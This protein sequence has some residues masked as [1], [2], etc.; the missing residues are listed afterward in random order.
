MVLLPATSCR[1]RAGILTY[2]FRG[3]FVWKAGKTGRH[4]GWHHARIFSNRC[5][6]MKSLRER[7]SF[8][9]A[10]THLIDLRINLDCKK[11]KTDQNRPQHKADQ[12]CKRPRYRSARTNRTLKIFHHTLATTVTIA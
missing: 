1:E 7:W 4:R 8:F 11:Y 3:F 10:D 2:L 12:N 5:E 6:A 9:F